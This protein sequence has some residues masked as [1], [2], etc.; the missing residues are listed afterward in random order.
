M[1]D[2]VTR[3]LDAARRAAPT[4]TDDEVRLITRA[5]LNE[6]DSLIAEND[7]GSTWPDVDDLGLFAAD[8][9]TT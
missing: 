5:V 2:E 6:L 1:S 8:I 9:Y 3:I 4:A 7:E